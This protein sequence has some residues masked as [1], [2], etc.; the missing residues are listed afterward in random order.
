MLVT[1]AGLVVVFLILVQEIGN[2]F[3][4][5]RAVFGF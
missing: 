5:V 4:T 1:V 3:D 2:L